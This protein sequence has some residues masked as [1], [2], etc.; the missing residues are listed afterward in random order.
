[1]MEIRRSALSRL[2]HVGEQNGEQDEAGLVE[3]ENS[4]FSFFF[5]KKKSELCKGWICSPKHNAEIFLDEDEGKIVG[6]FF[7]D[8]QIFFFEKLLEFEIAN[9]FK[10]NKQNV[11][12]TC[13]GRDAMSWSFS[14][15]R[16]FRFLTEE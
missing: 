3:F 5:K 1:M 13:C 12:Y 7:T 16:F 10:V 4:S 9:D 2:P 14:C 15:Q 8:E 11:R 6:I